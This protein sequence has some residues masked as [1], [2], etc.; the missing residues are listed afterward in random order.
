[1]IKSRTIKILTLILLLLTLSSC[2][3]QSSS[4][5]GIT[6]NL[7]LVAFGTLADPEKQASM[8]KKFEQ[9]DIYYELHEFRGIKRVYHRA[10]DTAQLYGIKRTILDGEELNIDIEEL[11]LAG[12]TQE[13]DEYIALF[14]EAGVR[15]QVL[16]V[17]NANIPSAWSI[18]YSQYYGPV[19]DQIRQEMELWKLERERRAQREYEK[20]IFG[21]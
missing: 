1:M 21:R 14:Q 8:L 20:K 16:E 3:K 12:G 5:E 15:F 19:V 10:E 17:P 7:G 2:D 13:R 18:H 4:E 9:E 6:V 11:V